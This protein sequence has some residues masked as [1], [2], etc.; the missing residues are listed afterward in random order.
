[1][2]RSR[3]RPSA[4]PGRTRAAPGVGSGQAW[5]AVIVGGMRRDREAFLQGGSATDGRRAVI[6]DGMN[7]IGSRPDG[8]WR[9]RAG[10]MRRLAGELTGVV[11]DGAE[12]WTVV[13][14][15]RPVALPRTPDLTVRFAGRGGP[16]AADDV[17]VEM[18]AQHR[19]AGRAVLVF[20]SDRG[21]RSRV[22]GQGAAVEGVSALR[23]RLAQNR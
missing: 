18:T 11:R 9:D 1:M 19:R 13:F 17:I 10:A 12:A 4:A 20:T 16:D 6:V 14:D 7:V 23:R 15:G 8:W 3:R 2:L 21:L 5:R 22:S